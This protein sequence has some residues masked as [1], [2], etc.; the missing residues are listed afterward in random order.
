MPVDV[1][2][3]IE[4]GELVADFRELRPHLGGFA[5]QQADGLFRQDVSVNVDRLHRLGD[6]GVRCCSRV[7]K[8]TPERSESV[9]HRAA[10]IE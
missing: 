6:H 9:M 4:G 10:Q 1:A 2:G 3:D 8:K 7:E 5:L